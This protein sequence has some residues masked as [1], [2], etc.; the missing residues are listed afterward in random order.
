MAS[1]EWDTFGK[2]VLR[3]VSTVE[4]D[5]LLAGVVVLLIPPEDWN[6]IF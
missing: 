2:A 1:V 4:M 5:D 6:F 3:L